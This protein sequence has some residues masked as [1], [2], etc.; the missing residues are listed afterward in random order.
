MLGPTVP[1]A[2]HLIPQGECDPTQKENSCM[3]FSL[4]S[5]HSDAWPLFPRE[6]T[7]FS[8]NM[9][10]QNDKIN[11]HYLSNILH[12]VCYSKYHNGLQHHII[13]KT[14]KLLSTS[15]NTQIGVTKSHTNIIGNNSPGKARVQNTHDGLSLYISKSS[16]HHEMNWNSS[17]QQCAMEAL[18]E[19]RGSQNVCVVLEGAGA[20]LQEHHRMSLVASFPGTPTCCHSGLCKI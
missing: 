7:F 13:K 9:N 4:F 11:S 10:N 3:D 15:D 18:P 1:Q 16:A 19:N 20:N 14:K 6:K 12:T 5:V 17:K 2:T 8:V